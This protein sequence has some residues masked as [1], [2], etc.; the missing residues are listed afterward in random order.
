MAKLMIT[1]E[2]LKK[3]TLVDPGWYPAKIK[4]VE[5]KPAQSDGSQN[6]NLEF[7]IEGDSKFV[8][9]PVYRTF[10]EKGAGFAKN[11]ALA[12]GAVID[13]KKGYEVD[14]SKTI[15]M[16][17]GIYVKNRLYEGQMKNEVADFRKL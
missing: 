17:I 1:P 2:D 9:V 3:G 13:E 6:F 12:C 4:N 5:E 7:L 11:F 10:N 8:G 16:K 15:G 14:F